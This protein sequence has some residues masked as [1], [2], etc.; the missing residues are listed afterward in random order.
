MDRFAIT[1]RIKI[2]K[3]YNKNGDSTT[4]TFRAMQ[5]IG[6][7]VKKFEMTGVVTNI[8]WSA[9]HRF[10]CIDSSSFSEISTILWHI[11]AYF[12]FRFA[13]TSI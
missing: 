3:T 10:E 13:P 11:M 12:A 6:K 8:E 7:I 1:Q 4:V 9:H 5:A 2:I